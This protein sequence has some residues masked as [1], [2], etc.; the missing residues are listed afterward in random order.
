MSPYFT[1][2]AI[3]RLMPA[4]HATVQKHMAR[5]A[6]ASNQRPVEAYV[7]CKILTFDVMV[8]QAVQMDM[9]DSE[10]EEYS[11]IFTVWTAG[12]MPPPIDLPIFPFGRALKARY[13]V[14]HQTSTLY[15]GHISA[16]LTLFFLRFARYA[17][18]ARS[19][20]SS[21]AYWVVQWIAVCCNFKATHCSELSYHIPAL[22]FGNPAK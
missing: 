6:A 9:S 7:A 12:F 15:D 17:V 18:H 22:L 8:N 21:A 3:Q 5:W 2:E 4:I 20:Q 13:V 16:Q 1:P 11:K 19:H 14:V 10:V